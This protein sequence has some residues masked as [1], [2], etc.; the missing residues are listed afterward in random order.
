VIER[1]YFSQDDEILAEADLELG[2]VAVGADESAQIVLP[3]QRCVGPLCKV[4]LSIDGSVHV[5]SVGNSLVFDPAGQGK[6]RQRLDHGTFVRVGGPTGIMVTRLRHRERPAPSVRNPRVQAAPTEGSPDVVPPSGP[7]MSLEVESGGLYWRHDL[8]PALGA[9][10]GRGE[11]LDPAMPFID[12]GHQW[13]S[14]EHAAVYWRDGGFWLSDLGGKHR[15]AVN[16]RRIERGGAVEIKTG[17][18]IH[19]PARP[20]C[21]TL[22]FSDRQKAIANPRGDPVRSLLLGRSA[23]IREVHR[24][25]LKLGPQ[26]ITVVILG[27]TGTGK[28]LAARA[29]HMVSAPDR[30]FIAINCGSIP[31]SLLQSELFGYVK[32]AFTGATHDK[33]GPFELATGGTVFLDEIGEISEAVQVSLLRVIQERQVT[34]VGSTKPIPIHSRIVT[35]THRPLAQMVKK[36]GI[37]QDFYQRLNVG[38]I[39]MPA[40]RERPEDIPLLAESWL[41]KKNPAKQLSAGA[42]ALLAKQPWKDGNVRQLQNVVERSAALADGDVLEASDLVILTEGDKEAL[43]KQEE[44]ERAK[45]PL[46]Q[47]GDVRALEKELVRQTVERCRRNLAEAARELGVADSTLRSRCKAWGI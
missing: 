20:G 9:I 30:P 21:P 41:A 45:L 17:D 36:G 42:L 46:R 10:V 26:K 44:E 29:I 12:L 11:P 43:R 6:H 18:L 7:L 38:E 33:P 37:R 34:R 40:L 39:F 27:E 15:V 24:L 31:Q 13:V 5:A 8:D 23:G 32:G 14:R 4:E 35:G 25:I 28:E 3:P 2:A 19:V 47:I 22:L 16:G 1:V